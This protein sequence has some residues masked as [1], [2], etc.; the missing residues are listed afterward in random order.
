MVDRAREVLL[1]VEGARLRLQRDVMQ[2]KPEAI[3][4][5]RRLERRIRDIAGLID[6]LRQETNHLGSD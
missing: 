1:N 6:S 5:D 2:G 3:E 4:A